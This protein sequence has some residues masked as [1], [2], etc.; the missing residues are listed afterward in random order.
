ME[1]QN[2][3]DIFGTILISIL[4]ILLTYA[5]Y[6]SYK[7]IDFKVLKKLEASPLNLPPSPTPIPQIPQS[8]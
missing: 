1:N 8:R 5:G 2:K 4:L 3:P 7:S 6:L